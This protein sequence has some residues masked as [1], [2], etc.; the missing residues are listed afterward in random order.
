[1]KS[2]R[3]ITPRENFIRFFKGEPTEWQPTSVDMKPFLP[4]IIPENIAR[5]MVMQQSPFPKEKFGGRG[6]F[7][8]DWV[9]EPEA[10][11]SIE[12]APLYNDLEALEEW[13]NKFEFPDL[14]S[15]LKTRLWR[16][17]TRTA[18]NMS[19][20]CLTNWPIFILTM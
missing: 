1:M 15:Y 14:D 17:W 18:G 16:C 8:V 11:G 10:G 4:E 19:A 13:E 20:P 12:T 3:T 2:E 5:G 9:F 7:N 6:M